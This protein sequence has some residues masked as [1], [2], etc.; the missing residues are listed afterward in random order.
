MHDMPFMFG[1]Q[2]SFKLD[3]PVVVEAGDVIN[4][5]CFYTNKTNA[6]IRFGEN[7]GNE[8][9]FNFALYYPAGALG[10]SLIGGLFQ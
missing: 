6:T 10:S 2:K 8:M 9:C 4:T 7:T 3:P 1:E 5:S